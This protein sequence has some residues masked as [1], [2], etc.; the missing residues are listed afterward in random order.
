MN[1]VSFKQCFNSFR[2]YILIFQCAG[3]FVELSWFHVFTNFHIFAFGCRVQNENPKIME[4]LYFWTY[5]VQMHVDLFFN[6]YFHF[7][8]IKMTVNQNRLIFYECKGVRSSKERNNF[9]IWCHLNIWTVFEATFS[10]FSINAF[11]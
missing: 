1:L 2:N 7:F 6:P 5:K 3:I 8:K 10:Y 4:N 11:L 9:W